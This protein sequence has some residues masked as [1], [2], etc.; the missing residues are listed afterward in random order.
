MDATKTLRAQVVSK[1]ATLDTLTRQLIEAE[2]V[3]ATMAW[4]HSP[5]EEVPKEEPKEE[6]KEKHKDDKMERAARLPVK[7]IYVIV[8]Q[9]YD[10]IEELAEFIV[11]STRS[12]QKKREG[13]SLGGAVFGT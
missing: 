2:Q 8:K 9:K 10:A 5:R 1:D 13:I 4:L 3:K 12:G 11:H 6:S 7:P